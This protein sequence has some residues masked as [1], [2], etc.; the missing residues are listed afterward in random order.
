MTRGIS[1]P[2]PVLG[3]RD[4]TKVFKDGSCLLRDDSF[5]L[6]GSFMAFFVPLTIMTEATLC[7]DQLVP[8]PKWSAT[9]TLGFYPQA[10]LSSEKQFFRLSLSRD[11]GGVGGGVIRPG[12]IRVQ[13]KE[14]ASAACTGQHH[15]PL[16]YNSTQLALQ[17]LGPQRWRTQGFLAL[18]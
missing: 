16:A 4:H 13:P 8:Q 14:E 6:V 15:P 1:M 17:E 10:S 18:W 2:I 9:L 5:V 11:T 12:W 3:L 7:L